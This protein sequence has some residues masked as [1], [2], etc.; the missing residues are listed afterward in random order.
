VE[1]HEE[2]EKYF[3]IIEKLFKKNDLQGFIN[4]PAENLYQYHFGLGT[5]IR[6][7]LLVEESLLYQLFIENY[8][9]NKDDMSSMIIKLFYENLLEN[10]PKRRR[11]NG[12]P[13]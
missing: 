5:W 1:L 6:N 12:A 2:I 4:T 8:I 13:L 3:P 7:N 9:D 11:I 10:Q